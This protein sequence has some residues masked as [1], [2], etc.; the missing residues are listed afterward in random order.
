[1]A[2]VSV[3]SEALAA[4]SAEVRG[5]ID[6]LQADVTGMQAGLQSLSE[7][8]QGQASAN[9]QS[10]VAQWRSTQAR[11]EESLASINEALSYAST[12]YAETEAANTALFRH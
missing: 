5:T 10:L 6:R 1:M 2:I 9:F 7:S 8:W 11:V 3:D 12:Q 4:K